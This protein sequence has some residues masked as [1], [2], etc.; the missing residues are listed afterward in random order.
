MIGST[1]TI[2][3]DLALLASFLISIV[4]AKY[5][6][7]QDFARTR[8]IMSALFLYIVIS[9][10]NSYWHFAFITLPYTIPAFFAGV[11]LGHVVGVRTEEQKITMQGVE[12]YMERFADIKEG[13][14]AALHLVDL[15]QLLF[16]HC[17]A[18]SH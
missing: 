17:C 5:A 13:G 10:T 14:R 8:F 16:H 9:L 6:I 7:A 11:L 4:V 18:H 12:R 15:H 1:T 2:I 3:I